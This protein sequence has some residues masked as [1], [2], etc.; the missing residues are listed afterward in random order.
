[1]NEYFLIFTILLLFN[2]CNSVE[3]GETIKLPEPKKEGGMPLYE[4]LYHRK[5]SREY[6]GSATISE[7]LLSQAL[8]S[9]Y[10]V[11]EDNHRT[12]PSAKAWYPFI[13]HVFTVDGIYKYL[14]ETHELEKLFDGDYRKITGTQPEIV[15]K[16][17]VNLVFIGDLEKYSAK[18]D[19]KMKREALKYDIGYPTMVLYLFASGNNMKGVVRGN[20]DASRILKFLG[21]EPENYGIPLAFSLGY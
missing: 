19:K 14:P 12:V 17:A 7:E 1:M 15:T 18:L 16:A 2:S 21:Y 20:I 10:G 9:C 5:T 6:D 11:G 13:I 8:W 3:V 4:A